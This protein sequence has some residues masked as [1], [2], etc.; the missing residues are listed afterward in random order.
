[1]STQMNVYIVL[2]VCALELFALERGRLRSERVSECVQR[3]E[4]YLLSTNDN[5]FYSHGQR[6][7]GP[8]RYTMIDGLI[9]FR[10]ML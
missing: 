2:C 9:S 7:Q 3:N 5:E 6:Y 1:M 8:E 4:N 10:L